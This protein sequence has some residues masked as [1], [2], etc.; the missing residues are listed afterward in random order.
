MTEKIL[1]VGADLRVPRRATAMHAQRGRET[2]SLAEWRDL[3]AYVLLGDPGAGKS[4]SMRAEAKAVNGCF[5]SARDFITLGLKPVDLGKILFIDGLDEMRAGAADGRAALDGIRSKLNALDH[6]RFRISCREHDWRA[7]TDLAALSQVAPDGTVSELHLEPLARDEQRQVLQARRAEVS[8]PDA[9]LQRAEQHGIGS[10]LSNPLLL[11]LTIRAVARK[12]GWPDSRRDIYELSCRDLATEHSSEHLD[13]EPLNPGDIDHLLDDAGLLCAVLLLSGKATLT[14]SQTVTPSSI[15]WHSLP[16]E[17]HMHDPQAALGSKI[18]ITIAGESAPCH[19]SIAEY[20]ASQAVAKQLRGGLPLR[21][22]LALMQGVDGGIVEPLRGLLGWLAVHHVGDRTQLI[23]LDPL[24]VVLNGDVAAFKLTDKMALLEALRDEAQRNERFRSQQWV[25]YP[26]APLAS[27]D[28]ADALGQILDDHST[29]LSHQALVDCVLDALNHGCPIPTLGKLLEAW[30][31]DA[32]ASIDTRI[33]ALRA[34]KRCTGFDTCKAREWL[35]TLYQ[36]KLK[37][38]DARLAGALLLDLYPNTLRP[39]EVLRYWPRSGAVRTNSVMPQFWHDGLID[40]SRPQDFAELA[41][42]WVKLSP[43]PQSCRAHHDSELWRLCTGILVNALEHS[44]EMVTDER[45]N[46][47]LG[48]GVDKHGFSKLESDAGGVR[49]VQWLTDRPQRIKAVVSL[50]WHAS[51]TDTRTGQRYFGDCESR[52]HGC[53]LPSDWIHWLLQQAS[54]ASSEDVARYCFDLVANAAVYRPARFDVPTLPQIE[55]WVEDH[56]ERWPKAH[57]WLLDHWSCSLADN[58]QRVQ[59]QNQRKHK[60]KDVAAKEARRKLFAPHLEAFVAGTAGVELM[61]WLATVYQGRISGINGATPELRV[62]DLLACDEWTAHAAI[63]G[64]VQVLERDDLPSADEILVL[65]ASGEE[66]NLRGP[67][68]LAARLAHDDK[69]GAMAA[70][71]DSLLATLVALWL[72]GGTGEIPGWCKS[73]VKSRPSVVA[74]MVVRHALKQLHTNGTSL[75]TGLSSLFTEPGHTA[76]AR[77]V[78][79]QLLEDFPQRAGASARRDLN[80]ALLAAIHLLDHDVASNIVRA[81]LGDTLIDKMQRICWLLADLAYRPDEV[82]R[83]VD[84]VGTNK[85][86]ATVLGI[87]L[88]EQGSL[89]QALS[90]APVATLSRLFELL[91]PITRPDTSGMRIFPEAGRRDTVHILV[92][93]LASDPQPAAATEL[94]RMVKLS[95]LAPWSAHLRHSIAA[96]QGE[97]RAAY[98]AYAEPAAVALTLANGAPATQADLMALTIDH[99]REIERHLRGGDTFLLRLFWTAE[100]NKPLKPKDENCCRDLLLDRLRPRMEPLGV[101]LVSERQAADEKRA[102]LRVDFMARGKKLAVPIEIKKENHRKLWSA[103][104][105]QLKKLYTIEPTADGHGIY[106]VLW[107]GSKL[108]SSPEGEKPASAFDLQKCLTKRIPELDRARLEVLVMDLSWPHAGESAPS[109]IPARSTR[110]PTTRGKSPSN[111]T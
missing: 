41:D 23:R 8:D 46:A 45:L 77:L 53:P 84:A 51:P 10:L 109:E 25:S 37:D 85:R 60:A 88:E 11:D 89:G 91:A 106:L 9:F 44:S 94:Q 102:D 82:Q 47:W 14:R 58:L 33:D 97:A 35:D 17:L 49:V 68:L 101:Q 20:L 54:D 42:A 30:V 56:V 4:E 27:L 75:G 79:P 24:G 5:V 86:R 16:A 98:Y 55:T 107:F 28:M 21:R 71:S 13:A 99:L 29:A 6:P 57:E 36:G 76:L 15:A 65:A 72:T 50:A 61:Q 108:Q 40:Q 110:R 63:A 32:N 96:Q 111:P 3:S 66:H 83:V 12:G 95:H 90:R 105:D 80:V 39:D 70:W 87:A 19:R 64:L 67:L 22:I 34:W 52:L 31:E 100:D 73:A 38:V 104:L 7:Q 103:C 43:Q 1:G 62:Q 26:F 69:P 74:S 78:L 18:F 2:R 92:N 48:I 93:R 59:Y 81:K